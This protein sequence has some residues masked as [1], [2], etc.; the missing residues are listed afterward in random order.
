L[1]EPGCLGLA[2]AGKSEVFM[3]IARNNYGRQ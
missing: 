3:K 1:A 2:A